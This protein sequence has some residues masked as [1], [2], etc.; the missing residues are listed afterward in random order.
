[1]IL[2]SAI[3]KGIDWVGVRADTLVPLMAVMA[4][5]RRLKDSRQRGHHMVIEYM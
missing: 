4:D 1:M 2:L 5:L 3:A